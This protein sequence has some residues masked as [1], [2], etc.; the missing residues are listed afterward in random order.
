ML[1]LALNFYLSNL[2]SCLFFF[3]CLTVLLTK[4]PARKQIKG[5]NGKARLSQATAVDRKRFLYEWSAN[6]WR[7][8]KWNSCIQMEKISVKDKAATNSSECNCIWIFL[9]LFLFPRN[10]C[11]SLSLIESDWMLQKSSALAAHGNHRS[12]DKKKWKPGFSLFIFV[13]LFFGCLFI[14]LIF[15]SANFFSFLTFLNI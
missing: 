14:T 8:S 7:Y 11:A 9:L 15:L 1:Y 5:N 10:H 6:D 12:F 13:L 4:Q 2:C 3:S